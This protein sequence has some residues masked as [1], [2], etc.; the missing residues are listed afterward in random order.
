MEPPANFSATGLTPIL[1]VRD[2]EEAMGYYTEKLLF[3][4][5]WDWG[6]PPGFGAVALGD[7]EIFFC[8]K[9][10]GQPGMWLSVFIDEV[11][12][13]FE[14]ISKLGAEIIQAPKNEPW[15]MREMQVRDPNGHVIRFGHGLPERFPKLEVERTQV[16][17]PI[18]KR[19]AALLEDIAR[20]KSMT[21]GEIFEETFLHTFEIVARGGVARPHTEHTLSHI[22]SLKKKH[23]IDYDCHA[24][25]RFEEKK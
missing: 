4:K 18:E 25:Y 19:L 24:S 22:Q 2:F 7:V 1:F 17:V 5:L 10:Q 13:Y 15:G 11:D 9:D 8:L 14:R 6:D 3:R 16:T 20:H 23:G 12:D 21:L